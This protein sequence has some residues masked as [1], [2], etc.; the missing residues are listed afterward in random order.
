MTKNYPLLIACLLLLAYC[1]PKKAQEATDQKN[2]PNTLQTW[3]VPDYQG[4]NYSELVN[5]FIGTGGHGHTYPGATAPFGLVQLSPD[6]RL[7]GWDG[8]SGYHYSD[9]LVYGFSHTHLSGTGVSDYGDVLLMPVTGEVVYNNGADGKKGYR[10]RFSHSK[11]KAQAGYYE[12]YLEDYGI[13][14][15]LT[16]TPRVGMHAYTFSQDKP[17]HVILDLLHRDQVLDASVEVVNNQEIQG[18]RRSKA[19]ATNQHVY[20]VIQFSQPFTKHE[21]LVDGQTKTDKKAESKSIKASFSF[22]KEVTQK[23]LLVKVGISAVSIEGARKNLQ[24]E[25]PDWNF[26]GVRQKVQTAWNHELSRIAVKGRT[27][28]E[29]AIFYTA[30]YHTFIAPNVFNDVDGKY[31]G[32]D[33]EVH[34]ADHP[35]FTVFSLWDTYRAAHPLYTLVQQKRTNDFIKTFLLQYQQGKT[36]PVWELAGNETQCMIGYHAV[37]VIVDAYMK[38]IKDYDA[39]LALQAMQTSANQNK[40]GIDAYRKYGYIPASEE[41]ESVSKTLEY[42]YDDWCIALMA[43]T[44]NQPVV[45]QDFTQRAQ[46]YKNIFDG[47]TGFM[48][49]KRQNRWFAPFR[50]AEVNFNYT[51]ANSWQYSL[52]VPQDISGLA[53]M[54]G[55]KAKLDQW[56]DDLFTASTETSGRHQAD[57]TGLIGQYAHG[58]EPSHHMAYLYNY[59]GKPWKTQQ[60]VAQIL[61]TLYHNQPDG[62]SGNEDCGQMSAWYVLSSM[63]FYPVTPGA[64]D[65]VIGSPVF[66]E[67]TLKLENGKS[68]TIKANN[69]SAENIY[70]QSVQ[71]NGKAYAKNYIKHEAIVAGGEL[72]INM[73]SAPNKEWG[74]QPEAAPVSAITEHLITPVPYLEGDLTF[75][76]A[77]HQVKVAHNDSK[78]KLFYATSVDKKAKTTAL[79]F[80][81]YRAPLNL[82]AS[83]T[84]WAFAQNAQGKNSDTVR[85][86]FSKIPAG[87]TI[88][89]ATKYANQYAAG[90]D[91]ALIDFVSGGNDFRTGKWQGYQ[92]VNIEATLDLGKA[93]KINTIAINCL[94]DQN[95]WIF[96]PTRVEF[97]TSPDGKKFTKVGVVENDISPKTDG[98]ILKKFEVKFGEAARYVKVVA[99]NRGI[100]PEWHL[101]A[102]GGAWLFADEITV[103]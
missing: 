10:S 82:S 23:P 80:V 77:N 53:Q 14:A 29:Q 31:R 7:T 71:L 96:M 98:S 2:K 100:V 55:G 43:K 32:R 6:T 102:G 52:Y 3:D 30:L 99:Y 70:I 61:S 56:L 74:S 69:V 79:K 64:N 4:K 20:F 88:S 60:R 75:D 63:G 25:A 95:S 42:A 8:C 91:K 101:G 81:P 54:L 35:Y 97:F 40:F 65:Y 24:T 67:A 93:E 73:G 89:L 41:P 12:T 18:H 11:E 15:A 36:L 103:E 84:V 85:T 9:S 27:A 5:P 58:N 39:N 50:P 51:E 38:G 19:W 78:V 26:D 57:I 90:G 28:K 66:P 92:K 86:R 1:A 46:A 49:A 72:V 87:R 59:V 44:M 94:Q 22:G 62:L 45:Y 47:N 48:R 33:A 37:P 17:A 13:K 76:Q 68:F 34:Q 21:L 83:T 16:A